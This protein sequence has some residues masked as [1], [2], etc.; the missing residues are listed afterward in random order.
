MLWIGPATRAT[1]AICSRVKPDVLWATAGP[2]SSFV[3]AQR[4]SQR[5]G[6]PYVLD[7]RDAWTVTYNKFEA[8]RPSWAIRRDRY[9]MYSLLRGAQAVTF[10]YHTEAECYSRAYPGALVPSKIHIIPNGYEGSIDRSFPPAGGKC[11]ILYS[12]TLESYRYDTLLEAIAL[13][14]RSDTSRARQLRIIFVGE[15]EELG[16]DAA[17]MG[18]LD[19]IETHNATSYAEIN[20]L[21]GNAHAL[22]VLGRPSSMKGH[23]LFAG[24]K[25]FGYLKAGRPIL[26]VLPADETKKILGSVGVCTVADAES[27]ANIVAVLQRLI[28]AWTN[29]N[30][31]SFTPNPTA[32]EIYS[33]PRQTA[34]LVR[35]LEARPA[36]DAFHPGC[37]EIPPS[38]VHEVAT[39]GWLT[40]PSFA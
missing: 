18:L 32:C 17:K 9:R 7:F 34:A 13:L 38:L 39:S 14:K 8:S 26:G 28:D 5:T 36:L 29:G 24:A 16:R 15:V 30:L 1:I 21:Q 27:P 11:T 12:G 22:L 37:A 25:L 19:I 3:V 20:R 31:R 35:A 23:E 2:V 6:I 10:R 33:A 4:V 40:G